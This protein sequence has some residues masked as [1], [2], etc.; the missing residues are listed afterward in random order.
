MP[1]TT[2]T[3]QWQRHVSAAYANY[4]LRGRAANGRWGT[5][6]GFPVLYLG[7]PRDSVI[8]EAYRH[9][10]DPVEFD[11]DTKRDAFIDALVPRVLVTCEVDVT[12]LLDL[13]TSLGR[14]N[15]NLTLQDL[16]SPTNDTEGYARCQRTAQVAHQL[17]RHGIITPAATGLGTTLA[18]FTDN[19]PAA[20]HPQR[21][22]PDVLWRRLPDD[23]RAARSSNILRIVEGG[24]EP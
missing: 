6:G 20:E 15:A 21:V 9:H 8:V 1:P 10:V 4:A 22:L 24:L 14:A 11:D 13:R 19:L 12:N 18:L 23:P 16:S 17:R 2:A 3:G 7:L 5:L